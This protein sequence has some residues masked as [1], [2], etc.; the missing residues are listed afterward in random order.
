M[1]ALLLGLAL[2]LMPQVEAAQAPALVHIYVTAV[3]AKGR[4]V[5][6]LVP[7]D[8]RILEDGAVRRVD[9]VRLVRASGALQPGDTV[10]P[11]LTST[12]ERT[13]A[14]HE[15][16]RVIGLFLDEYHVSPGDSTDV[17]RRALLAFI[18]DHLGPRDLV[19]VLRPL[20]SLLRIRAT[21]DLRAVRAMVA[22]F[23]GRKGLLEP[24]NSF[25][26]NFIA[27][28]HPQVEAVRAQISTS[29]L[30]ALVTHLGELPGGRKALVIASEGF[31]RGIRRRGEN[32]PT[33]S[34]LVRLS[35]RAGVMLHPLDPRRPPGPD[36]AAADVLPALPGREMLQLLAEGT[37]GVAMFGPEA[38]RDGLANALGELNHYYVV[39]FESPA[40]GD[41]RL[42]P[43]DV[44]PTRSAVHLRAPTGYWTDSPLEQMRMSL[45]ARASIPPPPPL[46]LRRTSP[47]IR[48]WFGVARGGE[49]FARVSFVWEPVDRLPGVRQ[50][51]G[52]PARVSMRVMTADGTPVFEG[53]VTSVDAGMPDLSLVTF[54][55]PAGRL[56]IELSI[57]DA[58]AGRLDTDVRDV[59]VESPAGPV[60][61]GTAAVI[62]GRTARDMRELRDDPGAVPTASRTFSRT[63]QL[64]VRVPVYA[65]QQTADVSARLVSRAGRAMR[66]LLVT[67]GPWPDQQQIDVPLAALPAGEYR[68]EVTAAQEGYAVTEALDFRIVP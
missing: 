61:L 27:A 59:I 23:E 30:H 62:R 13:E 42:R 20:D 48:P 41:G 12:D 24:R 1:S 3:D 31:D 57:E 21:R 40:G 43:I 58:R 14:A 36:P 68:L 26:E 55:A 38:W 37:G 39:G 53:L 44:R 15:G 32:L 47:L 64:L 67:P 9:S 60:A 29:V 49:G 16:T 45:A 18:D 33:A 5:D 17:V 63:E 34:G 56:R 2:G 22:S 35:H 65:G 66:Q 54:D 6:G 25:E 7:D 8:F 50:R 19:V 28:G 10:L 52:D 46:P 11:I 4:A 51:G